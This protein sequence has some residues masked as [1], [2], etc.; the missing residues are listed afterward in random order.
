MQL[1][2][3]NKAGLVF[4]TLLASLHAVWASLVALGFAQAIAD[5]IFWLHRIKPV[6]RIAPFN[7]WVAL[8]LVAFTGAIGYA[9]GFVLAA[10]WNRLHREPHQLAAQRAGTLTPAAR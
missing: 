9:G 10:L 7:F 4:G 6:Y 1:L 5:F 2:N 8:L 3:P